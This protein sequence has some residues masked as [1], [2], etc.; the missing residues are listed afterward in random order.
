MKLY[1]KNL[2]YILSIKNL[3]CIAICADEFVL[4]H[5][6]HIIIKNK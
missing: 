6:D 5:H 3:E 2:R 4:Y 1:D